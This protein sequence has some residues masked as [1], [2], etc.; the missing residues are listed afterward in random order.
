MRATS[1]LAFLAA[2]FGTSS[3]MRPHWAMAAMAASSTLSQL[4]NLFSS[5]QIRA[6][7]LRL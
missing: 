4:K 7:T 1:I 2:R 3:G 6:M 5:V